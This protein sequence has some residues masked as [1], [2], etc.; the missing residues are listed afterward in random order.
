MYPFPGNV[1]ELKNLLKKSIVIADDFFI[2]ESL[3]MQWVDGEN[4]EN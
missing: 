3:L 1:R 4:G 2:S